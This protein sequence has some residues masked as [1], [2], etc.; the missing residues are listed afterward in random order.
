MDALSMMARKAGVATINLRP[1]GWV[2]QG[3]VDVSVPWVLL[4]AVSWWL[5]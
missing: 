5:S 3:C 1:G 2:G 4:E